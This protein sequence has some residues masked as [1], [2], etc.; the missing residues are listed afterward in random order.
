[1][2]GERFRTRNLTT[3]T[4]ELKAATQA[5]GGANADRIAALDASGK[6][7]TTMMPTGTGPASQSVQ[8]SE[9]LSAGDYVN[10]YDSGGNTRVQKADASN[11]A[12]HANGFVLEDYG[13]GV[14]A[15]VYFFGVND[16]VVSTNLA[17]AQVGEPIF[18]YTT[19]VGTTNY[20][21]VA[22]LGTPHLHQVVGCLAAYQAGPNKSTS[23][24]NPAVAEVIE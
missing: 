11:T 8:T 7:D 6:W 5:G 21:L 16:E 4:P 12:K 1:M 3:G 19:G 2:A 15:T 17:Q 9:A 20:A 24:F 18:L 10:V 23:L 14:S 22:A 13:S